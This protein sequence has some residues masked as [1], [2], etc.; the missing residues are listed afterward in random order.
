[1]LRTLLIVSVLI[2]ILTN[3][4][5]QQLSYGPE[6]GLSIIPIQ[7]D[8]VNGKV[9]KNGFNGGLYCAYPINNF[10][11]VRLSAKIANGYKSYIK[12]DTSSINNTI[13]E[14]FSQVDTSITGMIGDYLNTSIT[15]TTK[16]SK[17]FTFLRI[18][19]HLDINFNKNFTLSIG[20]YFGALLKASTKEEMTQD[21]PIIKTIDPLIKEVPFAKQIIKGFYPAAFDPEF[22]ESTNTNNLNTT[23]FGL[24]VSLHYKMENNFFFTLRYNYGFVEYYK[25]K[26]DM[27]EV[28]SPYHSS[29]NISIG[30]SFGNIYTD[31]IKKRYNLDVE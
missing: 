4:S 6:I 10:L 5:A 18:P 20:G 3:I 27:Y 16:G 19:L 21:I 2:T 15:S 9:F 30:Y 13:I 14:M 12:T 8:N 22:K 11:S 29:Y 25:T 24:D 1:M 23:D 31:K 7:N 17:N 26:P 28:N